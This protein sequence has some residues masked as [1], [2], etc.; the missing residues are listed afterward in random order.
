MAARPASPPDVDT[1]TDPIGSFAATQ[2]YLDNL[3]PNSH[4]PADAPAI[5]IGS[6]SFAAAAASAAAAAPSV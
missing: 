6:A 4:E 5:G 1:A 3:E 2:D